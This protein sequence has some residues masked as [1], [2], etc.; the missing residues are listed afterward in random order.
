M[1][2]NRKL[3]IK[4]F[5]HSKQVCLFILFTAFATLTFGQEEAVFSCN[6]S[7][8]GTGVELC[9]YMQVSSFA[10]NKDAEAAVDMI[11]ENN[12]LPRNFNLVSCPDIKNAKAITP[13]N[14]MRYIVYDPEF[15][16]NLN[17]DHIDWVGMSILA[18][19]LG[20]HLCNHTLERPKSLEESRLNEL[21]ADHYS[22]FQMQKL[23]ATLEQAQMAVMLNASEGDDRYSTHPNKAKRLE[24]IKQGY[25]QAGGTEDLNY[26]EKE[27]GAES[28]FHQATLRYQSG[29]LHG[30]IELYTSSIE[31]N[32][33]Y[34]MA[35]FY[36]GQ[37][38]EKLQDNT[39]ALADYTSAINLKHDLYEGYDYRGRLYYEQNDYLA[40]LS[41][42][43]QAIS[44]N[45][46]PKALTYYV[47]GRAKEKLNDLPGAYADYTNAI[48][49]ESHAKY[50]FS[51]GNVLD[52]Q[53]KYIESISDF[54]AAINIDPE[55]NL[56][57]FNRAAVYM[58][59][60]DYKRAAQDY[61]TLIAKG[62][63]EIEVRMNLGKCYYAAKQYLMAIEAFSGVISEQSNNGEAFFYRAQCYDWTG[64]YNKAITDY[65]LAIAM[66]YNQPEVYYAKG[67]VHY[68]L[69]QFDMAVTDLNVAIANKPEYANAI[70]LR[71][72]V[73]QIQDKIP[74]ACADFTRACSLGNTNA[75]NEK[76]N[77]K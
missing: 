65:Y 15:I 2:F 35:F 27:P 36:R 37:I 49:L 8:D 6:Y 24:S 11:L 5:M 9:D 25:I 39:A 45:P 38:K 44:T 62:D 17:G 26:V 18:H 52:K 57:Y 50:Y 19:E 76:M 30:A 73:L 33:H 60:K 66:G 58:K 51:R 31:M 29:D 56:A 40:C 77:C 13:E 20:H 34:A 42:L 54:T 70:F 63:K 21:Q 47:R 1:S 53:H 72:I 16:S 46:E 12:G 10:S 74:E 55:L 71:G 32:N 3:Y 48:N 22:G 67:N 64:E 59:I 4:A 41:D 7:D 75:C 23:G 69:K 61:S 68:K 14:K 43:N 28:I